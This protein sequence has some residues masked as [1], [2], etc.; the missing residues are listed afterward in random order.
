MLQFK[1]IAKEMAEKGATKDEIVK[2]FQS[3]V[4]A[5]TSNYY[6][7]KRKLTHIGEAIQGIDKRKDS[8]AEGIFYSMLREAGL[9]VSFQVKIGQYRADYLINE[10]VII[11]LDGPEHTRERDAAKDLY[12]RKMGYKIIRVPLWVLAMDPGAAVE[13]IRE[14]SAQT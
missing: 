9:N 14:A 7:D 11:E 3:H 4:R 10:S 8:T 2:V 6:S 13:E 12:V 5:K 1:R